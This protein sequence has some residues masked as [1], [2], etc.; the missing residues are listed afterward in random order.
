L[1]QGEDVPGQATTT[2]LDSMGQDDASS[3]SKESKTS[4]QQM[5]KK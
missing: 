5:R 1:D 4:N 2:G 3:L